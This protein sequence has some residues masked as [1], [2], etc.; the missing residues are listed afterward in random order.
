MYI[1][2]I[3]AP[4]AITCVLISVFGYLALH[5]PSEPVNVFVPTEQ[6]TSQENVAP[7][8]IPVAH[9][10]TIEEV[11]A[12]KLAVTTGMRKVI[13]QA[14]SW[15]AADQ[16]FINIAQSELDLFEQHFAALSMEAVPEGLKVKVV[17]ICPVGQSSCF[18]FTV[19]EFSQ[20]I[21]V[22][23][24]NPGQ[25]IMY[26]SPHIAADDA[27][28]PFLVFHNL[29]Y[30]T[31][32]INGEPIVGDPLHPAP[33]TAV[34]VESNAYHFESALVDTYTH[35]EYLKLI[36]AAVDMVKHRQLNFVNVLP[37]KY[38]VTYVDLPDDFKDLLGLTS[39]VDEQA[40]TATAMLDINRELIT[41]T[42]TDVVSGNQQQEWL[43]ANFI[44]GL[45]ATE[46]Q[47]MIREKQQPLSR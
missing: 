36:I 19:A 44:N 21:T 40:F 7:A 28:L 3:N 6:P 22:A 34:P 38:P 18:Y 15:P 30:V 8:A 46:V 2:S 33:D 12:R 43:Y 24:Y 9:D 42:A 45:H 37:G 4:T 26:T 27:Y 35:G 39:T 32:A 23:S 17:D 25:R 14:K 5:Q 47:A 1:R 13:A 16:Q 31:S 41:R 20:G 11:R 10:F 29:V